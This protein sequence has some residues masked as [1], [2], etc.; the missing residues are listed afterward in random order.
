[1]ALVERNPSA[2]A[3]NTRHGFDPWLGRSPGDGN[4]NSLQNS[5]LEDPMDRRAWWAPVH[6]IETVGGN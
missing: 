5:C 2:S 3:G 1:M 6:G 4:D